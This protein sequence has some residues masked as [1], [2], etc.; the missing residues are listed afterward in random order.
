MFFCCCWRSMVGASRSELHL[1]TLLWGWLVP[2]LLRSGYEL[3]EVS[4]LSL[5]LLLYAVCFLSHLYPSFMAS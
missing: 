1:S 5:A 3:I 4:F 2:G